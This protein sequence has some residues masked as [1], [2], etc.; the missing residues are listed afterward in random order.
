MNA[1]ELPE[2]LH[3]P[4]RDLAGG[5][6]ALELLGELEDSQVL[7]YT[8]LRRLQAFGDPFYG[9][10]GVDQSLVPA[11]PGEGVEVLAQVVLEQSFDEEF[12]LFLVVAGAGGAD[13]RGQLHD[14]CLHGG[15]VSALAGDQDVVAV[16]GGA[17]AD[18]LQAT[19]DADRI[20]ELLELA[21]VCDRAARVERL[22]DGLSRDHAEGG[23]RGGSENGQHAGWLRSGSSPDKRVRAER[24]AARR[25]ERVA[26][27]APLA[28]AG[29]SHVRKGG[30][31]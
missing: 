11:R 18:R 24:G 15:A 13:D 31:A 28:G 19:V 12:G 7:T 1:G 8:R 3:C 21:I 26:A 5:E 17:D 22:G 16:V 2:R 9:Q 4:H 30:T 20:R 29:C 6:F 25:A 27:C 23:F 10:A 14:A